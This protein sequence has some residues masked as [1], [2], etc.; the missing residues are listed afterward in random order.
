[1]RLPE[2]S[3][4]RPSPGGRT[5]I[6]EIRVSESGFFSSEMGFEPYLFNQADHL[7]TQLLYPS[8]SIGLWSTQH[9]HL[10]A[11]FCLDRKEDTDAVSR[12]QT[13]FGG[14]Q[15]ASSISAGDLAQFLQAIERWCT[16]NHLRRLVIRTAPAAYDEKQAALLRNVYLRSRYV[17][18]NTHISQHITVTST[19]FM[20]RIHSSERRR[21]R[22]CWRAG[23]IAEVWKNPDPAQI[24]A[25]LAESRRRQGYPLS[26]DFEQF[27][28]LLTYLPQQ[29]QVFVVKDR[30]TIISLTVGIRVNSRILYNFCPADH[31]DYRPYSPMVLLN[32]FLYEYAQ[33]TKIKLIDLGISLDHLGNEKASLMRFK[34]NLGAEKSEKITYVKVFS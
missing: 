17:I 19:P 15:T 2:Q 34:E 8:V 32:C 18:L 26:L 4:D 5:E 10:E 27:R 30:N 33:H 22:K 13:P 3:A 31:L 29:A 9:H 16:G 21:L 1:M 14:I 25:F 24:Y 7:A 11:V 6:Y 23:F 20:N 28:Q 12:D